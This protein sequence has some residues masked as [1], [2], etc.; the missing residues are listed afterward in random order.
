MKPYMKHIV[1]PGSNQEVNPEAEVNQEVQNWHG[2][3]LELGLKFRRPN[4]KTLQLR[5]FTRPGSGSGSEPGSAEESCRYCIVE[6]WFKR[7]G[8]RYRS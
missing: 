3:E 1:E 7:R 6:A 4:S 5:A 2:S 8:Y